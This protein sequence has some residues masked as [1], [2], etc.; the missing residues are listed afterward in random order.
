MT[1]KSEKIQ[2]D[3]ESVNFLISELSTQLNEPVM[4][5]AARL[6]ILIALALNRKLSFSELLA[7]TSMGKGSLSNHLDKMQEYG[8]IRIRTVLRLSGPRTILEIT[9]KGIEAYNTYSDLLR[10]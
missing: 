5:S 7:I 4:K 10:R 8:L 2:D 6:T 1:S 3:G 9:E